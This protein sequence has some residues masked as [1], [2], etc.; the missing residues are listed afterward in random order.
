MVSKSI[1]RKLYLLTGIVVTA[2]LAAIELDML[3]TPID[4]ILQVGSALGAL[5]TKIV[6]F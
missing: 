5:A 4:S 3:Q 6:K 1:K 2:L